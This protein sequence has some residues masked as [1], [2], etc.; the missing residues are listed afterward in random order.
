MH[1]TIALSLIILTAGFLQGLTGFGFGLIALPLLGFFIPLKTI[2]PLLI[3]LA[4]C[5]S[6][7]LSYQL[8][9]AIR[10]RSIVTLFI[11][12][13]PGIP[14]GVFMLKQISAQHLS[15][16]L[17][18]LM[19]TFTSYQLLATPK[20]RPLGTWA[21]VLAGVCSGVL[22]GSI[23]LGGPPVIVY[24]ALQPWTKDQSKATLAFFFAITGVVVCVNHALSGLITQE[25]LHYFTISLP[26]LAAGISLGVYGYKHMSDHG[27][28]KLSFILVFLLGW[29]M[30][31]R[32]I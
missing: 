29:M 19:I 11:A 10:Y 8:R 30:I 6:F 5:I 1:E 32:N 2:I 7:Y 25:V 23:G 13:L 26:A 28:R 15:L 24:S 12:T 14:L 4:L 18:V 17:G 20:P 22:A 27:Y 9:Q 21:D 3:M 16:G 31:Y